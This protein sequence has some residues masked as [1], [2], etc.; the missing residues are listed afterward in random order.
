MSD[1]KEIDNKNKKSMQEAMLAIQPKKQAPKK[2]VVQVEK[3]K[4]FSFLKK[5][6]KAKKEKE[7]V[8]FKFT[9][10]NIRIALAGIIIGSLII[11][12]GWKINIDILIK[13]GIIG[14]G[15]AIILGAL[16]EQRRHL[17]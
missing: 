14:V 2:K 15:S 13:S 1:K 8:K 11:A 17:E 5:D 6:D 7:K 9:F 12:L 16:L 10:Y 3:K 4:I